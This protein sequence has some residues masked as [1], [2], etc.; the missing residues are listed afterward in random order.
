MVSGIN[1]LDFER[2][3]YFEG[4]ILFVL[5]IPRLLNFKCWCFGTP[6]SIFTGGVS[7][8]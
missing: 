1:T 7:S 6:S 8:L 5:S 3:P 4:C 2:L